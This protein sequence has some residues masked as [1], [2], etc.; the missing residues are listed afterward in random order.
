VPQAVW[1]GSIAFGLVNIPVKLYNATSP[2]DVRFHEFQAG[3]ARR[4]RHRR[5]VEPEPLAGPPLRAPE[6]GPR[7]TEDA[8]PRTPV[9]ESAEEEPPEATEVPEV[10][11]EDVVKGYE[12]EP[13]RFVMID[14]QEL[15]SLAPERTRTIDIAEFV[16]LGDIDPVHFEKSYHVAP[17]PGGEKPY[18]LLHRAMREAGRVAV[19]TFVMRTREYLAAV[20]PGEDVLILETLFYADE[21][22]DPREIALAPPAEPA[23]RELDMAGRLIESLVAAWDPSRHRD[24]YRERVLQMI[25][26]R[27]EG[28]VP[29]APEAEEPEGTRIPDLMAALQASLEAIKERKAPGRKP[30]GRRTTG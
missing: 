12:I 8:P 5:V 2:K 11:F 24:R 6:P 26:E 23:P 17:G 30:R 1:T 25:A 13:D 29:I 10:P 18:W 20:R 7:R 21:V 16:A 4:I 3:T 28:A 27:A 15:E 19:A 22:R 14:P 9:Q